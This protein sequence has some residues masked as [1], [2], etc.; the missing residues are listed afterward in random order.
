MHRNTS[1]TTLERTTSANVAQTATHHQI[2]G[3]SGPA[4][5]P[6]QEALIHQKA[7]VQ[8]DSNYVGT[9]PPKN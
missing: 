8:W 1:G 4:R 9:N 7:A 2:H 6:C 3:T 5:H